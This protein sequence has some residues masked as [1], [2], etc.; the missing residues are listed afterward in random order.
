MR[1][2]G[3]HRRSTNTLSFITF[4][5]IYTSHTYTHTHTKKKK[6]GQNKVVLN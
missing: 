5:I 3:G 1:G 6:N 4:T 2:G